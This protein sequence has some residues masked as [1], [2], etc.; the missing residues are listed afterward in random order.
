MSHL[1]RL[2]DCISVLSDS[3]GLGIS[4]KIQNFESCGSKKFGISAFLKSRKKYF[5]IEPIERE[6]TLHDHILFNVHST[7]MRVCHEHT[8]L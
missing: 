1:F 8:A 3:W 4:Y 5:I 7:E 2:F 6:S